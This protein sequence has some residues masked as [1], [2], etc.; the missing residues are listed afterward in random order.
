MRQFQDLMR[1]TYGRRDRERGL[2]RTFA[3]FVEEVGELSR[4]V[5]RGDATDRCHEFADVLAWLASVAD[6]LDVDLDACATER[7]ADGCPK[8]GGRTVGRRNWNHPDYDGELK[9]YEQK[10]RAEELARKIPGVKKVIN[11]IHVEP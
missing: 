8:C 1:E 4:A 5:F 3:W 7:Y 6:Q 11:K 10:K 2:E 9:Q